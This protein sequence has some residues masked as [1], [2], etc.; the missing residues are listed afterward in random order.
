MTKQFPTRADK[1]WVVELGRKILP[2]VGIIAG[3]SLTHIS[4][5]PVWPLLHW[6][7]V[8]RGCFLLLKLPNILRCGWEL[9]KAICHHPVPIPRYSIYW[10]KHNI[11]QQY[12][13]FPLLGLWITNS[14]K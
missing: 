10:H 11:A 7:E 8:A 9:N 1:C 2:G 6:R 14:T 12:L 3:L 13:C 4:P 5:A